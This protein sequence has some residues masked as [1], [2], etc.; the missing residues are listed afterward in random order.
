[1]SAFDPSPRIAEE[2]KLPLRAVRA[3][4]QLLADGATVPFIARYRKEQTGGLDEVAIRAVD[5]RREHLLELDARRQTI[6]RAIDA[7][8]K[9]TP[10]LRR[11]LEDCAS[12]A[13]LEDLYAPYKTKRRTRASMARERGLEPLASRILAQPSQGDPRTEAR[14]FVSA[15]KEVPD[16][17]AALAGARDIVAELVAD[18][19]DVRALA[20]ARFDREGV[21]ESVR[22]P[23]KTKTPTKFEAYYEFSERCRTIPSHRV[24]AILRGEEEGALRVK[25][26][27]DEEAL[28]FEIAKIVGWRRG[29]PFATQ[30]EEAL[31]DSTKRLLGPSIET[32]VRA[33]LKERADIEAVKVF[34]QNL[35]KLLLAPPLG[36]HVVIGIDPGQR[37]GCKCVVVDDTGK[38]L[39]HTVLHLVQGETQ[40]AAAKKTLAALVTK[41]AP[42]AIAVGNGTHGRET[43]DFARAVVKDVLVVLV[44][45][46]GASVYSASDVAR[47]EMPDVDLTVRGAAS[48]ARRLQDPLAELVKL[49][50]K[51]I[52]VGQ[53]QHDVHQPLLRKKLDEVVESAVSSVGV[54]LNTASASLLSRV[55]GIGPSL[56]KKIVGHRDAQGG[57]RSRRELLDVAGLGPKAFEQAAGFIRIHGAKN[58]LDASAV[59]PRALSPR[60]THREGRR[61]PSCRARRRRSPPRTDRLAPLQRRRGRRADARGHPPRARSPRPGPAR[62]VH[63]ALLPRR[64][65]NDR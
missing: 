59:H 63:R 47:E 43:A 35:A 29:T 55:A 34:A 58:P 24:L 42:K 49:D 19:A 17:E 23:A 40:L 8:G 30:L 33:D 12:R 9:L 2:L 28:A 3:V 27:V 31:I 64:R 62:L 6:L 51:V 60:R 41:H 25:V 53:Y 57:F 32:D 16:V 13:A 50:P 56:A 4:A 1:M 15:E 46:S 39:T 18:R 22:V 7:Q 61:R 44:S 26:R 20:R 48:I 21:V 54:E 11:G 37:T 52:G 5:E 10:E 36:R 38:L 14:A 45:E 65:T